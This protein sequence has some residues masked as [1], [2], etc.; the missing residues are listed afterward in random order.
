M[1][2]S[3]LMMPNQSFNLTGKT[4]TIFVKFFTGSKAKRPAG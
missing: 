1:S 4:M 3:C 2:R